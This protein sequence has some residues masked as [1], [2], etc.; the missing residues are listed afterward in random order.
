MLT[1]NEKGC[2]N[3]RY[4]SSEMVWTAGGKEC[5]EVIKCEGGG[6]DQTVPKL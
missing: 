3:I 6:G 2:L 1:K 4:V 5:F